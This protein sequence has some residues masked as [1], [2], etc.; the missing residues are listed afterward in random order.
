MS[1]L[2][3]TNVISELVRSKPNKSV[4]DW[5]DGLPS[6]SF[7]LSVLSLGEILKGIEKLGPS[8]RKERLVVWLEHDL[9]HWFGQQI[10][11][12]DAIVAQRW[13]LITAQTNRTF[14]AI[15]S[16]LAATALTHNLTLATRNVKDF[17]F[18]DLSVVNPWDD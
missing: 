9:R 2:L 4:V 17:Q 18:P 10:L 12:I 8:K 6:E 7:Y 11:P 5:M 13:G 3:D 16:L 15:D 1:Y 14:P